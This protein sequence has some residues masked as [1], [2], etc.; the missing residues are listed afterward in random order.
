MTPP[1][2]FFR[3]F[4]RFGRA[5]RPLAP[6]LI[7]YILRGSWDHNRKLLHDKQVRLF[8]SH[9]LQQ[10]TKQCKNILEPLARTWVGRQPLESSCQSVACPFFLLSS[11]QRKEHGLESNEV[12]TLCFMNIVFASSISLLRWSNRI[13][14]LSDSSRDI[15]RLWRR[16]PKT[17][18]SL[19]TE[20]DTTQS[21]KALAINWSIEALKRDQTLIRLRKVFCPASTHACWTGGNL[22]QS[23][24]PLC[25]DSCTPFIYTNQ[26]SV[27][28]LHFTSWSFFVQFSSPLTF[29][30]IVHRIL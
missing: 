7:I 6:E 12:R 11:K 10:K 29:S 21:S 14:I 15:S 22:S 5:T 23:R 30:Q 25:S 16:V 27:P 28:I 26:L 8:F 3:K 13:G 20:S 24:P 19:K 17:L 9:F 1:L 18:S 2:E 4:I